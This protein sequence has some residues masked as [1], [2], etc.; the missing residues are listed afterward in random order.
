MPMTKD[1][2][3]TGTATPP[4]QATS[5]RGEM[6]DAELILQLNDELGFY[7]AKLDDESIAEY[8]RS[9]AEQAERLARYDRKYGGPGGSHYNQ[10]RHL[11]CGEP[12]MGAGDTNA[13]QTGKIAESQAALD[14]QWQ[15]FETFVA[16]YLAGM[17]DPRDFFT[18]SQRGTDGPPVVEFGCGEDGALR[19]IRRRSDEAGESALV[20]REDADRVARGRSGGAASTGSTNRARCVCA[21]AARRVRF[22][23]WRRAAS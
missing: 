10:F 14:D 23:R 2:R 6:T 21:E 8:R 20:R 11:R 9:T 17:L 22:P 15:S 4:S 19:C 1:L 13:E 16:V 3:T 12:L 18:I 7:S 5:S